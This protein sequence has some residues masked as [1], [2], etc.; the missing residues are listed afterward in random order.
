[1]GKTALAE[2]LGELLPESRVIKLGEHARKDGKN[3]LLFPLGISFAEV[4][5]A[6]GRCEFLILESGIILDDPDCR[7]ELVVFLPHPEADKPGA[8]RRRGRADLVRGEP[9]DP[10]SADRLRERLGVDGRTMASI[11]EAV[12]G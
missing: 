4:V 12:S 9:V 1:M 7:P 10:A 6:V 11:L 8:E 2:R 3:P 5:R